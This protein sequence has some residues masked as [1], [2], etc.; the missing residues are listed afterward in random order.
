[1]EDPLLIR[2][3]LAA[4]APKLSAML[5]AQRPEYVAFFNPFGFDEFTLTRVLTNSEKD[6]FAGIYCAGSLAGFFMLRGWDE[7]FDVPAYGVLIDEGHKN[8]GLATVTLR[9]AKAVCKLRRAPRL[10]L[11]VSP[12]NA[13][14][15]RLFERAGF[16]QTGVNSAG[17]LLIYHLDF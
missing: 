6:V 14:A 7:G 11:K 10:M 15:K 8:Y 17:D 5:R 9:A 12:A 16:R 4:D 2:P 3:L 1:M 13:P